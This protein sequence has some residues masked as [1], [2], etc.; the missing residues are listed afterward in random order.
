MPEPLVS[1]IVPCYKQ[2]HFLPGALDSALAQT[3]PAVEVVVV[4]DGSPD[5]TDSVARGYGDRIRYVS[6]ANAGLPAARN[7][8]IAASTGTYLLFLDSDDLLPP[9]A[10]A[11]AVAAVAGRDDVF[12]ISG[13]RKFSTSPN[14]PLEPDR[15]PRGGDPF[16]QLLHDNP[17]PPNAYL[18]PRALVERVGRFEVSLRSCEDW[19]LWVRIA[20]TGAQFVAVPGVGAHYRISPGSMSTNRP[21]MLDTRTEVLLRTYAAFRAGPELLAKWGSELATAAKRVRRRLRAQALFPEREAALTRVLRELAEGGAR[22]EVSRPEK[23]LALVLGRERAD[24]AMLAAYRRFDRRMFAFYLE[25]H[26]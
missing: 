12:A 13:W 3:H 1:V 21:R 15:F 8:G 23:V 4:N 18:V 25:G 11:N 24:R 5:D 17:A 14:E 6:Q 19:D 2:A 10:I 26:A 7:A 16:P 20:L 9:E 22:P